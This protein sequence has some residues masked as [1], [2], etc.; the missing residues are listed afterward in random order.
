MCILQTYPAKT[1]TNKTKTNQ[2]TN[3]L[4]LFDSILARERFL[5]FLMKQPNYTLYNLHFFGLVELMVN[6]F[7]EK[8][9]KVAAIHLF[10]YLSLRQGLTV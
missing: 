3:H 5:I 9:I 7:E 1:N 8:K 10:V 6:L 4:S 2:P